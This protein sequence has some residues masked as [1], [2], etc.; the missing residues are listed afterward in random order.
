MIQG[1]L[2]DACYLISTS[3]EYHLVTGSP[4][5]RGDSKWVHSKGQL[6]KTIWPFKWSLSE[7]GHIPGP[8]W[9]Q[10]P[11][12]LPIIV[13]GMIFGNGFQTTYSMGEEGL[14]RGPGE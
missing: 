12:C 9:L 2:K 5:D 11:A 14:K 8:V 6:D 1:G 4:L 7:K 13:L 10:N 3:T